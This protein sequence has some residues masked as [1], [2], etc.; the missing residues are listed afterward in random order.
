MPPHSNL[1]FST[2]LLNSRHSLCHI[3]YASG[4]AVH[5]NLRA[6]W[7]FEKIK[8][9]RS[10]GEYELSLDMLDIARMV[11][12]SLFLL[13]MLLLLLPRLLLLYSFSPSFSIPILLPFLYRLSAGSLCPL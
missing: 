5:D 4:A 6:R 10:E 7:T 3:L 11:A 9:L 12:S 8:Q 2:R 13:F 1:M